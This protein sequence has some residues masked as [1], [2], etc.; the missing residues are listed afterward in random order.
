ML[1]WSYNGIM[2]KKSKD[3]LLLNF[4][5]SISFDL[6]FIVPVYRFR[7]GPR[8]GEFKCEIQSE[9]SDF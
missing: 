8:Y 2:H 6:F 7:P 3:F 4:L 1:V 5:F 9:V